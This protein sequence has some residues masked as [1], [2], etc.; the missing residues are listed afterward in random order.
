MK[1]GANCREEDVLGWMMSFYR[2]GIRHTVVNHDN[3]FV[4]CAPLMY[5]AW[6]NM[7]TLCVC[8]L[9]PV[10]RSLSAAAT[11]VVRQ[12]CSLWSDILPDWRADRILWSVGNPPPC[13]SDRRPYPSPRQQCLPISTSRTWPPLSWCEP[14]SYSSSQCWRSAASWQLRG[15]WRNRG[16]MWDSCWTEPRGW[17]R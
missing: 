11:S 9:I 14:S 16:M 13:S 1:R 12:F 10:Q 15:R 17:G 6:V 5:K 8:V 4:L 3:S 2:Q 7:S